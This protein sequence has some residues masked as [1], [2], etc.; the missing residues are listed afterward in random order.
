MGHNHSTQA[1]HNNNNHVVK[2][3]FKLSKKSNKLSNN[4]NHSKNQQ[5]S[6]NKQDIITTT[7]KSTSTIT[8]KTTNIVNNNN[9]NNKKLKLRGFRLRL[10]H[11]NKSSQSSVF[12]SSCS[13]P[14]I[15]SCQ[16]NSNSILIIPNGNGNSFNPKTD[17]PELN[18]INDDDNNNSNIDDDDNKE[19]GI[20]TIKDMMVDL[21]SPS[22]T[23]VKKMY[24][25]DNNLQTAA[26]YEKFF[27]SF[28]QKQQH[29]TLSNTYIFI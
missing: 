29:K 21:L 17:L 20:N 18:I 2:R 11:S 8:T 13:V 28:H 19:Q 5:E 10:S 3:K 26:D 12:S 15:D 22:S 6:N 9:E 16:Q 27:I 7:T 25:T 4:N 24:E 14:S 23:N 1:R